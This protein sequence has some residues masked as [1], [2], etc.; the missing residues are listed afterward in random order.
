MMPT[1]VT[2]RGITPREWIDS[3]V[4]KRAAKLDTYCPDILSCRVVVEIPHKHHVEGNRFS[5]RISL[6]VPEEKI[7]VTRDSNLHAFAK[8]LDA[9]EWVKQLDK[10]HQTPRLRRVAV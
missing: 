6:A 7:A 2:F 4:R 8:I 3:D 5:V 9:R 1:T 10:R